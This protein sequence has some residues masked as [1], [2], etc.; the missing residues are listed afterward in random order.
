MHIPAMRNVLIPPLVIRDIKPNLS[1]F[2][3]NFQL[4]REEKRQNMNS[5]FG[6]FIYFFFFRTFPTEMNSRASLSSLSPPSLP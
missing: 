5:C 6:F 1:R 2:N 3:I 4:S